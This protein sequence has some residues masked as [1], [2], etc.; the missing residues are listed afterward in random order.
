MTHVKFDFVF[1]CKCV[2]LL[3]LLLGWRILKFW[4]FIGHCLMNLLAILP[5]MIVFFNITVDVNWS[6]LSIVWWIKN[7]NCVAKLNILSHFFRWNISSRK[8][9]E[10]TDVIDDLPYKER[11]DDD[12]FFHGRNKNKTELHISARCNP[13]PFLVPYHLACLLY[14]QRASTTSKVG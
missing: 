7:I 2:S 12:G 10:S 6:W 9:W 13:F 3:F 4:K 11:Y 14:H 1:H 8:D 5:T